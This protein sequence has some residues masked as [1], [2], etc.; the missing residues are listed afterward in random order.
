MIKKIMQEQ[1]GS[2]SLNSSVNSLTGNY[3]IL[4]E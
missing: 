4:N 2:M 1:S 3:K